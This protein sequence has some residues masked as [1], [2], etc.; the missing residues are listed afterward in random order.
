MVSV[1][2][3]GRWIDRCSWVSLTGLF[4]IALGTGGIKPCVAPFGADQFKKGQEVTVVDYGILGFE[5]NIIDRF[6]LGNEF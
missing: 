5:E 3:I 1:N 4:I 6:K 2:R